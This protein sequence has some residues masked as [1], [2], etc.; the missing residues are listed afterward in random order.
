MN[1]QP[2]DKPS[3]GSVFKN[4]ENYK[5]AQLIDQCG[6]KGFT[7]GEAQ[8]STKHANFIVNLGQAKAVDVWNVILHVQKTV[9]EKTGVSI[10]TEVIRLGRW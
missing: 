3:C 5:V 6:L 9:K 8:V 1:K 7:I 4:P 2:L 10:Q